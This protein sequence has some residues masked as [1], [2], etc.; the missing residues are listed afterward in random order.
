MKDKLVSAT[1]YGGTTLALLFLLDAIYGAGSVTKN[2]SLIQIAAAGTAF[3]A[4]ACV[5]SLFNGRAGL[6]CGLAGSALCVPYFGVLTIQIP[7]RDLGSILPYANWGCQLTALVGV[8]F[9]SIYS[10]FQAPRFFQSDSP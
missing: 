10:A 7:W 4:T 1:I 3:F 9:S 6:L 8:V 5:L 2:R